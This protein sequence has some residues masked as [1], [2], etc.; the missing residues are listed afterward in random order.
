MS[1][2]KGRTLVHDQ[3]SDRVY[4]L[5]L[6][7]IVQGE[8]KS[9][10]RLV[11]DQ[12]ASELRTSITPVRTALVRLSQEGL[13]VHAPY[14]G[15]TV[16][17][18][19]RDEIIEIYHVRAALE[20]LAIEQCCSKVN[21]EYLREF[22]RCQ[23]EGESYL[24]NG[25][26]DGYQ[27]Y[28]DEFHDLI[29]SVADNQVLKTL[30]SSLRNQVRLLSSHTIREPGRPQIAVREHAQMIEAIKNKACERAAKLMRDHILSALDAA[31][32]R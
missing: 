24:A 30:M 5:L 14:Q 11:I 22:D 19:N 2:T 7:R 6:E 3:L 21:E 26:L 20:S 31:L 10:E 27:R 17:T 12:I 1:G 23:Q 28:N 32:R 16:R 13:L 15:W 8:L 29:L 9:G 4:A 25:D 18:F